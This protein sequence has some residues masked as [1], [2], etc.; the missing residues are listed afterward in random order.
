[1]VNLQA[2]EAAI[3]KV[4][5]LRQNEFPFEVDGIEICLRPLLPHEET[6]VQRYAQVAMED[7][8]EEGDQAAFADFMDRMRHATLAFSIVQIGKLD[9]R[10]VEYIETGEVDEHGNPVSVPKWE[11][12]RDIVAR[13]WGRMMLASVF[14]KF[15]EM[16]DRLEIAT[17]KKVKFEPVD[18]DEE[19]ERTERRLAELKEAKARIKAPPQDTIRRQQQAVVARD[20]ATSEIHDRIRTG[21]SAEESVSSE[22]EEAL[23][24]VAEEES[25]AAP[26]QRP[27]QPPQKPQGRRS[28]IPETGAAPE[29]PV[30]PQPPQQP[31][32]E[33]APQP[34]QQRPPQPEETSDEQG[35]SLPHEG[36]SFFDPS[37]PEAA[38]AAESRRQAQMHQR[39]LAKQRAAAQQRQAR[40][41]MGIPSDEEIQ[42]ERMN[43]DRAARSPK[44][45]RLDKSPGGLRSAANVRD[46]VFDGGAG[47]IRSGRPQ[48][49]PVAREGQ[50]ATLHGKPVYKMP[51]QTLD[52][53]QHEQQRQHGEPAPG[54][55]RINTP[56]PGGRQSKFRGPGER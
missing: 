38:M 44:G 15:G 56:A 51:A 48:P 28:A 10:G 29:R 55:V 43:S 14:G 34:E 47:S 39:H 30:A 11:A 41:A 9:L 50:A 36:D 26:Q 24:T 25:P 12:V 19:I 37:D 17:R 45:V 4:E 40:E 22:V 35:I 6:E 5:N 31:P 7:A 2:L 52:R 21:P 1:M 27:P 18:V 20:E 8:P 32:Y 3:S 46:A 54:P 23:E 13:D 16:L 33:A 49:Q 53:P 42:A